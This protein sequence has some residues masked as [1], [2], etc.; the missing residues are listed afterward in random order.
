MKSRL[1]FTA[2]LMTASLVFLLNLSGNSQSSS[3]IVVYY[4][5]GQFRC[6]SCMRIEELT[7]K[8]VQK[9]FQKELASG[10]MVFQPV[11]IDVPG[12]EHFIEDYKLATRSVI[13]S[14]MVNGKQ[15]SWKNLPMVWNYLDDENAFIEYVQTEVKNFMK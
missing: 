11:N 5:Y 4:F 6:H 7:R 15:M 13:L 8:A 2:I 3:K 1:S 9:E 10:A 14:K 12:N